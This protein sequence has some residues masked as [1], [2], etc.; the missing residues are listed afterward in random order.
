MPFLTPRLAEIV[1]K[2]HLHVP[3]KQLSLLK[4]EIKYGNTEETLDMV[5][6]DVYWNNNDITS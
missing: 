5:Y 1:I 2:N 3:R 6:A 4:S